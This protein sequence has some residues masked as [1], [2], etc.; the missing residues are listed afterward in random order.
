VSAETEVYDALRLNAGIAALVGTRIY[1]Q[2][3]PPDVTF[4]AIAYRNIDSV[5]I[6]G[7]CQATRVQIDAYA[8]TYG[9]VKGVRDAVKALAD[10]RINWVFYGGPDMYQEGQEIFHQSMDV[11][12]F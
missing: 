12:V 5:P 8:T 6:G 1:P 7:T 10:T 2:N 3:L 11:R 4:P 9:S